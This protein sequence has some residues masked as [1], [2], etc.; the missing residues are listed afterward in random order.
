M[1]T[2]GQSHFAVNGPVRLH[3]VVAGNGPT[4]LFLHGIPDFWNGWRY[5]IRHLTDTHRVVAMDLRGF[6]ESGKP[7]GT[8]AYAIPE[9]VSDV[10]AVVRDLGESQ[11]TLVGH[12]WGGIIAWWTAILFPRFV[13]SLFV[14]S[15]PHPLCYLAALADGSQRPY[16][17]Y[18]DEL[19][20]SPPGEPLNIDR[21]SEWVKDS[22]ARQELRA[23]LA[24]SS[25]EG[26]RNYYRANLV[27]HGRLDIS[28]FPKVAVPSVVIYGDNDPLVT[29]S[30]YRETSA[31]VSGALKIICLHGYGHFLHHDA[32][33]VVNEQ[34]DR[35]LATNKS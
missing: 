2:K 21:W 29:P 15:A 12:D 19:L 34:L 13:R 30:A 35:T 8:S 7:E 23:A 10:I 17:R 27:G 4:V 32:A 24:R 25:P 33:E 6:N 22:T 11:V 3:Y 1:E 31:F 16:T 14:I 26:I 5:Q 9:L 18:I 20:S 28:G